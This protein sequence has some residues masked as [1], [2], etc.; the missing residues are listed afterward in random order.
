METFDN[1]YCVHKD[2]G[3]I[4]FIQSGK[5][6]K[7][8]S[9]GR[10][11]IFNASDKM[12]LRPLA[13]P[14]EVEKG[15]K[16]MREGIEKKSKSFGGWSGMSAGSEF[17]E[18]CRVVGEMIGHKSSLTVENKELLNNLKKH[19]DLELSIVYDKKVRLL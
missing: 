13:R 10:I 12:K 11:V 8:V 15:V 5:A 16:V 2:Y 9:D 17:P 1:G 4:S 14:E 18:L 3:V 7:V 19:I 6:I